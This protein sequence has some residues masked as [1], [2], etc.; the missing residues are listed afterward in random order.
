MTDRKNSVKQ[1]MEKFLN[2]DIKEMKKL[3]PE[4]DAEGKVIP[5]RKKTNGKP[6]WELV[7]KP[8]LKYMRELGWDVETYESKAT[9]SGDGWK[10][11]SMKAGTPDCQGVMP[12]GTAVAV[13]FKAPGKLSTFNLDKNYRQKEF[14]EKR[15]SQNAFACVVDSVDR[16]HEIYSAWKYQKMLGP[17]LAREYLMRMLP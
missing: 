14:I 9:W 5:K 1:A 10:N 8:C 11:Q 15:I 2:K 13:E 16:L 12:D 7:Q 17:E 6:E 3:A 4:I